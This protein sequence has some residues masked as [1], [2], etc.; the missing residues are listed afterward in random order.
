MGDYAAYEP[1]PP[2][3]AGAATPRRYVLSASICGLTEIG[4]TCYFRLG[5]VYQNYPALSRVPA[6]YVD[7]SHALKRVIDSAHLA[8]DGVI[9]NYG[10][11]GRQ[12]FLA[13]KIK[14]VGLTLERPDPALSTEEL[15]LTLERQ[16]AGGAWLSMGDVTVTA[17]T[18][19]LAAWLPLDYSL[20]NGDRFAMR[21]DI[22]DYPRAGVFRA[23]V[24]L[25][26]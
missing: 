17:A 22:V 24:L 10:P 7:T 13:S 23:D 11:Y 6:F 4:G 8:Q 16:P 26:E 14:G 2:A 25:E 9:S 15:A 1:R 18:A 12:S 20:V 5:A 3:A 19:G 21:L